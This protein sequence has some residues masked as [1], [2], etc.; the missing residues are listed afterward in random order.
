MHIVRNTQAGYN[1]HCPDTIKQTKKG[2][3]MTK[4]D[5]KQSKCKNCSNLAPNKCGCDKPSCDKKTCDK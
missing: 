2:Y 5:D 3:K 4:K 1:T